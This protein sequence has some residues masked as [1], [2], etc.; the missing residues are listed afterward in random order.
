MS[1][2]SD[3]I[4]DSIQ[5]IK[6]DNFWE[7]YANIRSRK[8]NNIKDYFE[9]IIQPQIYFRTNESIKHRE[10]EAWV[11][12]KTWIDIYQEN[13]EFYF[14]LIKTILY[15]FDDFKNVY[16]KSWRIYVMYK[17]FLKMIYRFSEFKR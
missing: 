3:F 17:P 16:P 8:Y 13:D 7:E 5:L 14:E 11:M 2:V 12:L 9:K 1:D 6:D 15:F 4:T 10:F